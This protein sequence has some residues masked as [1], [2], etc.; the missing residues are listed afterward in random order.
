MLILGT[1]AA[2]GGID[3]WNDGSKT[4]NWAHA[5]LPILVR[6]AR[7]EKPLT[8]GALA[9]ELGM[10]HHRPVQRAAGHIAYALA[11]IG[12]TKGW[13]RRV[14]PPLQSLVIN[15]QTGLPGDGVD[16]FM[17]DQYRRAQTARQRAAVLKGIHAGIYA[18]PHWDDVMRLLEV[19]PAPIAL[20]DISTA[21][22]GAS[23]RG[24]EGPE[25]RALKEHVATNPSVVGL[26]KGHEPGAPEYPLPSGDRI[27][28]VFTGDDLITAVEVKSRI[29]GEEDIARGIY[30][31]V[32]YRA[33]LEARSSVSSTPMD[34]AVRL[35][36]EG[37]LPA[38]LLR[39]A[40]AF[41]VKVVENVRPG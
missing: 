17:S 18:Y 34:V 25:H 4:G 35:V 23:G 29:S 6:Q 27:D 15:K 32:K 16:G 9:R 11:E 5:M 40:N 31:C 20:D 2:L 10:T 14:P 12:A 33:V 28:V 1:E 13:R 26:P 36:L 22:T 41:S 30:Q 21:A 8:Y 7:S 19:D 3:W 39:L 24:G 37:V 38:R